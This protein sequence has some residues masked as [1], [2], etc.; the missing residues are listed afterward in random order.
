MAVDKCTPC[1]RCKKQDAVYISRK[2]PFCKECFVRFVR[3]KQRKQMADYKVTYAPASSTVLKE[4]K[5]LLALSLSE[6]SLALFEMLVVL[7]HE[8]REMHRNHSG[9]DLTVIHINQSSVYP[10]TT[11]PSEIMSIIQTQYSDVCTA[12]NVPIDT[13]FDKSPPIH[14]FS[15]DKID[16]YAF[17]STPLSDAVPTVKSVLDGV[18]DR[19]SK[20]D[21]IEVMRERI[22]YDYAKELNCST[23]LWGDSMTRLAE[24]TLTLTSKGRGLV[25]PHLLSDGVRNGVYNLTPLRDILRE[26][27]VEYVR[28]AEL[29]H[30]VTKSSEPVPSILRMMTIDTIL[31]NYFTDISE[32]FPSIVSTVVRTAAKLAD[33]VS[34]TGMV[35]AICGDPCD[36]TVPE[37]WL[38][39]ITVNVGSA[40][41]EPMCHPEA[42][43]SSK[44]LLCYGCLVATKHTSF[45]WPEKSS[46]Q[47]IIDQYEIS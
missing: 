44:P 12:L 14:Q 27:L 2:E 34:D 40:E 29:S 38:Q 37:K 13:F 33:N 24:K 18:R 3:G 5:V 19:S 23:V 15:H 11:P 8:Q 42:E 35:C 28:L 32:G 46:K 26:E 4:P 47:E 9:F 31:S 21:L 20:L 6:S 17:S 39:D 16:D 41:T 45:P 36:D 30:L 22:I 7:L 25:I 10:H 1:C 43:S